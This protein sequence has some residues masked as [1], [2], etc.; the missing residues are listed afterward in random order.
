MIQEKFRVTVQGQF[1]VRI[2]VQNSV[3]IQAWDSG[4]NLGSISGPGF[5]VTVLG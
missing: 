2:K 3:K 1:R 4:E 5:R